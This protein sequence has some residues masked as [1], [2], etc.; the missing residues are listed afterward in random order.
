MIRRTGEIAT[1]IKMNAEKKLE[2]HKYTKKCKDAKNYFDT[3]L[4][5]KRELK[6]D[7]RKNMIQLVDLKANFKYLNNI[8]NFML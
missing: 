7:L 2:C 3:K 1:C 8:V 5:L 4:V 6:K